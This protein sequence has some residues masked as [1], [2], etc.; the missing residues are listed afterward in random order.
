MTKLTQ[1]RKIAEAATQGKWNYIETRGVLCDTGIQKLHNHGVSSYTDEIAVAS[2]GFNFEID[3]DDS[4]NMKHIATFSPD[5]VLKMLEI[6]GEL[7]AMDK[8][9]NVRKRA[10]QILEEIEVSE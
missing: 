4:K 8:A 1:L 5:T 6:I 2:H 3:S 10:L 9:L 7:L